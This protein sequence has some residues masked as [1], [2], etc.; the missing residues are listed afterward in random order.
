MTQYTSEDKVKLKRQRTELAISLAMRNRWEEA[1]LANRSILEL[2]PEEVEAFNRLGKALT[3][4]GRYDEAADAYRRALGLDPNNNIAHRNLSRLSQAPRVEGA[5][6]HKRDS[7]DPRLFIEE[8]GKTGFTEL[9]QPAG[10]EVLARVSPGDRVT[11][12]VSGPSLNV[13]TSRGEYLGRVLPRLALRLGNLIKS[14]NQYDAAITSLN[15]GNVRV[16][17]KETYQH[18]SQSGKI[19]FPSRGGTDPFRPYI[20]DSLLKYGLEADEDESLDDEFREWEESEPARD[21]PEYVEEETAG[22]DERE[23]DLGI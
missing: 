18:P 20:K 23:R 3:E 11:L 1:A 7:V 12:Q 9:V 6:V 8:T 5:P 16:I 10:N 2:F 19:S 17:I 13:E 22:S 4:L 14:G 15:H 21:E